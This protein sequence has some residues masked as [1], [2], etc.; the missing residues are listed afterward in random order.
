MEPNDTDS[1]SEPT[2]A[3]PKKQKI[4]ASAIESLKRERR[5][6]DLLVQ[7]LTSRQV[8]FTLQ[9][10]FNIKF[11]QAKV[12]ISKAEKAFIEENPENR[13]LLRAKYSAMLLD[14]YN[15]SYGQEHFKVC[16]EIIE[17]LAKMSGLFEQEKQVNSNIT[18]QYKKLSDQEAE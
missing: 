6:Q 12:Y 7:G 18:I 3:Q 5:A 2:Q 1:L 8:N 14:L 11:G 13:Q 4:Q 9:K 15:K 10:E 17:S 16:R